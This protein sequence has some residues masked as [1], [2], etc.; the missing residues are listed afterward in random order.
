MARP[1]SALAHLASGVEPFDVAP[2]SERLGVDLERPYRAWGYPVVPALYVA[3]ALVMMAVLLF[4]K[5]L[6]TW[7]GLGIVAL[8]VPVYLVWRAVGRRR[9]A[10]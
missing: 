5:P 6:Y 2:P 4:Y 1:I 8:G 3:A 9:A 7:P 10:A